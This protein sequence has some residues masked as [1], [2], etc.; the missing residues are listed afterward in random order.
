M[1]AISSWVAKPAVSFITEMRNFMKP[2]SRIS[3]QGHSNSAAP[4]E[5]RVSFVIGGDGPI[6]P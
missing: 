4:A 1:A 5:P 2:V 3:R 6:F